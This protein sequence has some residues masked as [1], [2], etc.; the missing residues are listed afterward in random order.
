[1]MNMTLDLDGI[2]K[3]NNSFNYDDDY[4]YEKEDEDPQSSGS[5]AVLIPLL[6]SV[7][8][9]AGLLGNGLLIAVLS[10]KKRA[11]SI[12]DIFIILLS[13]S[14]IVL[15]VTLPLWAAQ[16]SQDCGWCFWVPLSKISGAVFNM[17]FYC[18]MFLMV[19][20]SWNHY[21]SIA[22]S[23]HLYSHNRSKLA[24]I[25]F[26]SVSFLLTIPDWD[27][28]VVERTWKEKTLCIPNCYLPQKK[29]VSRL[30]HH[31][32]GFLLPAVALIICCFLLSKR[33]QKQKQRATTVILALVVVFLSCWMPYNITLIV[34]TFKN[35]SKT[36]QEIA[37]SE[38]SLKT[39]L[40]FTSALACVHAC[41]RPVLYFSLCKNFRERMLA[42][43]RCS[44]DGDER[45]LW[46]L[47]VDDEK[48]L[49]AKTHEGES[50]KQVTCV[51]QQEQTTKC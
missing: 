49:P 14:D 16:T 47:G 34:D 6:Y 38:G 20:I 39:A 7:V 35:R 30:F 24:Y 43:L 21:L 3:D 32:L 23:T 9:I 33:L 45:S 19:S 5:K 25:S 36:P 48:D 51:E 11:W 40:L 27:F 41:L 22:H 50:L 2:F 46:E 18:G 31:V 12:S 28:F 29:L 10:Q 44:K 37:N 15:L 1:M 17:N 13:V 4:V 26:L 8:L 42:L